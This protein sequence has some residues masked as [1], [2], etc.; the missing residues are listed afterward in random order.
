[1]L[2]TDFRSASMKLETHVSSMSVKRK[3]R[4]HLIR[5]A[6]LRRTY[7]NAGSS[8]LGSYHFPIKFRRVREEYLCLKGTLAYRNTCECSRGDCEYPIPPSCSPHTRND[9]ND[10][11]RAITVEM[12]WGAAKGGQGGH[13]ITQT[14]LR[15][16]DASSVPE[17]SPLCQW[18]W[19]AGHL[20]S[21]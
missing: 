17:E 21:S 10:G 3:L 13:L 14:L 19:Q 4:G 20:K 18:Q 11:F 7:E 5:P 12:I 6:N 2:S 9:R 8:W 16:A 15:R 1:M